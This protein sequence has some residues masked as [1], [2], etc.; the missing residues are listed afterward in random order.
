MV[1]DG[2][3]HTGDV[4]VV[5]EDGF[6]AITD[7]KKDL[8]ITS[9]GKNVAPSVIER[10]LISDPLID[11]AVLYGDGRKFMSALFVPNFDELAKT[12]DREVAASEDDRFLTGDDINELLE[13]RVA[14]LM[15]HVSQPERVRRFLV[16]ARAFQVEDD[17]L[18]ATLKVRRRHII[19]KY[20]ADL[21]ALYE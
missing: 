9:G 19:A 2:W 10:L 5:D 4:G 20:E 17:E 13:S 21:A 8:M 12:L 14:A 18:T 7:R 1:V 6:L 16:L 3:L 11:Q 15:E